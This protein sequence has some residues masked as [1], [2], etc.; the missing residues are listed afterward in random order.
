MKEFLS[1]ENIEFEYID[2]L[3]SLPNLKKF[4]HIRDNSKKF[5]E[6]KKNGRI[7]IPCLLVEGIK[8]VFLD[9]EDLDLEYIKSE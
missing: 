2:I 6:V 9:V 7:G 4:L 5:D 1:K 8:D 3:E